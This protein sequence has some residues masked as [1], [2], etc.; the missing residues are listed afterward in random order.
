MDH[1]VSLNLT[2][3]SKVSEITQDESAK[4]HTMAALPCHIDN[5]FFISILIYIQLDK[6]SV[7]LL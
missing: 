3:T 2:Y 1:R 5:W 4:A 7:I 6:Q